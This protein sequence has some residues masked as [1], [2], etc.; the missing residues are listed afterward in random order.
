MPDFV[1]H[2][3]TQHPRP[4]FPKGVGETW[5]LE[6]HL[7]G[8]EYPI[9]CYSLDGFY[10]IDLYVQSDEDKSALA[11]CLVTIGW[12]WIADDADNG[13]RLLSASRVIPVTRPT[14][15]I[16]LVGYVQQLIN[17]IS[18]RGYRYSED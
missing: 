16:S 10:H 6:L 14:S 18:N 11:E 7:F 4:P 1:N 3:R 17:E 5:S 15:R 2:A 13:Y 9:A 8:T 12:S